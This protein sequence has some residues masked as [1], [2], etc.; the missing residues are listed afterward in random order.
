MALEKITFVDKIEVLHSNHVQV[1][2][3]TQISEN[4]EVITSQF[5][6]H[7]IAPGDDYS[8]EDERVQAI[9]KVIHTEG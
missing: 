6:R 1:R 5:H 9:C 2:T 3:V 8:T 4:A 7:V